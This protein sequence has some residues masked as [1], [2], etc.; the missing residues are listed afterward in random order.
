MCLFLGPSR[1]VRLINLDTPPSPPF[2]Y[3]PDTKG[4]KI[5]TSLSIKCLTRGFILVKFF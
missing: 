5:E 1:R 2:V 4:L 3:N